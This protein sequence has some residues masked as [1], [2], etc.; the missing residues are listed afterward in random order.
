MADVEYKLETVEAT[1]IAADDIDKTFRSSNIGMHI[2][3]ISV[4]MSR[5]LNIFRPRLGNVRRKDPGLLG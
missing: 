2:L 5:Q 4:L 3:H 1:K